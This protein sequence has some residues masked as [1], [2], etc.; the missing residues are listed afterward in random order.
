M[1]LTGVDDEL[2][3]PLLEPVE[4]LPVPLLEE[5][6]ELVD[7]LL[8]ELVELLELDEPVGVLVDP[9]L[10]PPDCFRMFL[11]LFCEDVEEVVLA[12]VEVVLLAVV[13]I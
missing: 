8:L 7:V 3:E 11:L 1:P 6:P 5:L 12:V 10:L 13:P 2:L 9:T 4:E